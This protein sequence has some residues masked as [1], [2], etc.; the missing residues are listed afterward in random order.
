MQH[1]TFE[2]ATVID[3]GGSGKIDSLGVFDGQRF[4]SAGVA[5]GRG[6]R[7]WTPPQWLQAVACAVVNSA[8]W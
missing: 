3:I 2:I 1:A 7:V 6:R 5:C 8:W 4:S